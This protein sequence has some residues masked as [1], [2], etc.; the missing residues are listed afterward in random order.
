MSP[1]GQPE[2]RPV[3]HWLRKSQDKSGRVGLLW[4]LFSL[5]NLTGRRQTE[6]PLL[7]SQPQ[8]V[9]KLYEMLCLCPIEVK[10]SIGG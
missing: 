6:S 2:V 4:G 10:G 8:G 3:G 9:C 7:P 5:K 1:L